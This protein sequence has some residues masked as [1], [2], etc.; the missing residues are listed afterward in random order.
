MHVTPKCLGP[1]PFVANATPFTV[2]V[3]ATTL[4]AIDGNKMHIFT[5][6]IPTFHS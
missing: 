1:R 5:A 2:T 6:N 4:D 3:P